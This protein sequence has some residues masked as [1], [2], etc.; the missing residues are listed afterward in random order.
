MANS[1]EQR[2]QQQA[3]DEH[4]Q[5][6]DCGTYIDSVPREIYIAL[7]ATRAASSNRGKSLQIVC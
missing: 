4:G 5:R 7:K 2:G 3:R 6:V 1:R